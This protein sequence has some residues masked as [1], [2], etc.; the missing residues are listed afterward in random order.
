MA[1]RKSRTRPYRMRSRK[2]QSPRQDVVERAIAAQMAVCLIA[3]LCAFSFRQLNRERFVEFKREYTGLL[4]EGSHFVELRGLAGSVGETFGGWYRGAKAF[5]FGEEPPV[6]SPGPQPQMP[7]PDAEDEPPDMIEDQPPGETYNY[8]MDG[9]TDS[10]GGGQNPPPAGFSPD[11]TFFPSYMGIKVTP[12]V[13]GLVTSGF[14][15][16]EHPIS[17]NWSFHDA[18]DIAADEGTP[19]VAAMPGEVFEIGFDKTYGNYIILKHAMHISTYYAHCSKILAEVGDA[20]W[21]GDTIA[22]VGA[23]GLTTGPH[24]H[25]SVIVDGEHVDPGVVLKEYIRPVE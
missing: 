21:Q 3:L 20:V 19:I 12:P 22:L 13:P 18:I 25:F 2:S 17:G 7:G 9:A 6:H 5:L 10:A 24:L 8:L 16:R 23:T 1:E 15:Y 14:E 4:A 11:V